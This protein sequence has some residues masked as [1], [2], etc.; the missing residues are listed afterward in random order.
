MIIKEKFTN[1]Y[2]KYSFYLQ[3]TQIYAPSTYSDLCAKMK[4]RQ[5][6]HRFLRRNLWSYVGFQFVTIVRNSR[7]FE[8][9][10]SSEL[11][12]NIACNTSQTFLRVFRNFGIS[13]R[14]FFITLGPGDIP[15]LLS[16]SSQVSS[17]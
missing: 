10:N 8:P 15:H 12:Y 3:L 13:D 14:N 9:K 6:K 16:Q 1:I 11:F 4:V 2:L 5:I 7:I 17:Y